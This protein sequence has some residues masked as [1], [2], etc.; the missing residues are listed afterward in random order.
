MKFEMQT[1]LQEHYYMCETYSR[2]KSK[3]RWPVISMPIWWSGPRHPLV[4]FY[5]F[6]TRRRRDDL[7]SPL[8]V[9]FCEYRRDGLCPSRLLYSTDTPI[10]CWR[11]TRRR[12]RARW[13]SRKLARLG[14]CWGW[15]NKW[16]LRSI[17]PFNGLISIKST[18]L[19]TKSSG[20]NTVKGFRFLVEGYI[21][22]ISV[23]TQPFSYNSRRKCTK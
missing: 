13:N 14:A 8:L 5:A 19:V 4:R 10:W 20:N 17:H 2:A 12:V 6:N 15:H 16:E 3:C 7:H 11:S 23:G 21:K 1:A 18:Y 9:G 22:L